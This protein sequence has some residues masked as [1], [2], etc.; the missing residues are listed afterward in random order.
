MFMLFLQQKLIAD[1][2][3]R[4]PATEDVGPATIGSSEHKPLSR[5]ANGEPLL[6]WVTPRQHCRHT[7]TAE[8]DTVRKGKRFFKAQGE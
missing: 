7:G 3:E 8:I 6:D 5:S 2:L 1:Q 4:E